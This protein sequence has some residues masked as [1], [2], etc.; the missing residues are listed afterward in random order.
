MQLPS[1][2]LTYIHIPPWEG[3]EEYH[4][5][6]GR[7]NKTLDA[8]GFRAGT[9]QCIGA[10]NYPHI[11]QRRSTDVSVDSLTQRLANGF[12]LATMVHVIPCA[13]NPAVK[14]YNG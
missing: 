9:Y 5:L 14:T 7:T 8:M 10:K 2:E 3:K 13:I 6:C 11:G 4:R 12:T 1:G